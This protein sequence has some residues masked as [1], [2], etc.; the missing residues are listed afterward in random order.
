MAIASNAE[1]LLQAAVYARLV[2][3]LPA[4]VPVY[5]GD[6]VPP[7]AA[8]P[9]VTIGEDRFT[10]TPDKT[11]EEMDADI[12]VHVWCGLS[13]TYIARKGAKELIGLVSRAL[14]RRPL[15]T[16]LT[17]AGGSNLNTPICV[18][19][20]ADAFKDDEPDTWHGVA[21]FRVNLSEG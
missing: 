16:E 11:A 21:R 5:D 6:T 4:G 1:W 9:Y 18:R 17:A 14:H 7:N 13:G 10:D 3:E 19:E 20:Y 2:A 8:L 12:M 15:N